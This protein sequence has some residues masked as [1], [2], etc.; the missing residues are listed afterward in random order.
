MGELSFLVPDRTRLSDYSI[1]TAHLIGF[2]FVPWEGS[3]HFDNERLRIERDDRE[4]ARLVIPWNVDAGGSMALSTGTL[5]ERRESYHLDLELA[6]GTLSHIRSQIWHWQTQGFVCP[7]TVS[8]RLARAT[9]FFI[10]AAL[11]QR[12][13]QEVSKQ[14]NASIGESCGSLSELVASYVTFCRSRETL[15][16]HIWHGLRLNPG[17]SPP[18]L[19]DKITT[20]VVPFRW[21]DCEPNQDDFD[22]SSVEN[23]IRQCRQMDL[24]ILGGQLFD[25]GPDS[26]PD[27][28]YL[29]QGDD[30]A[31]ESFVE[32]YTTRAVNRFRQQVHAWQCNVSCHT[33][34][35][36]ML[37][38]EQRLRHAVRAIEA[39]RR[40]DSKAPL[41]VVMDQPWAEC[42][43]C[44]TSDL[45]PI[46]F[47]DML[48]RSDL[49]VTGFGLQLTFGTSLSDTL[50]RDTLE[51][52][53]LVDVWSQ[54]G[55]PLIVFLGSTMPQLT[56]VLEETIGSV[57][58]LFSTKR[59]VQGIVWDH[60]LI[61]FSRPVR[62]DE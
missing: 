11:D 62:K 29:W 7:A 46:Q 35:G 39:I 24:R 31:L 54:L 10:D 19:A 32:R 8:T 45:T 9:E 15:P 56:R 17:Q 21:K 2:D 36:L 48:V 23:A 1:S 30:D 51:F 43:A 50:L 5:I 3:T 26:I 49:N 44:Q 38:E 12:H 58:L 42:M 61:R 33:D 14:A 55:K 28:L 47:A 18:D 40:A 4:S 13:P 6:R 34:P 16:N 57:Q 37:T 60:S 53:R 27:W 20:A 22:W 41:L 25:L 52:G 59:A